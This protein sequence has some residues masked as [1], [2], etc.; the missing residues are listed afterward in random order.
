[1][2]EL[3]SSVRA[4][5]KRDLRNVKTPEELATQ[6]TRRRFLEAI[7]ITTAGIALGGWSVTEMFK[8]LFG[9]RNGATPIPPA[10]LTGEIKAKGEPEVF[11]TRL[12]VEQHLNAL[13]NEWGPGPNKKHHPSLDNYYGDVHYPEEIDE[14]FVEIQKTQIPEEKIAKILLYLNM[15]DGGNVSNIWKNGLDNGNSQIPTSYDAQAANLYKC[16]TYAALFSAL[17]TYGIQGKDWNISYYKNNK[18]NEPVGL[19]PKDVYSGTQNNGE[20]NQLNARFI[21]FWLDEH[22]SAHGWQSIT[23]GELTNYSD[24]NHI[25]FASSHSED[26][27]TEGHD[28]VYFYDKSQ[29]K[30]YLTQSTTNKKMQ[31]E[32]NFDYLFS[33]YDVFAHKIVP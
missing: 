3:H 25:L 32:S 18:T 26:P 23:Q 8:K 31:E 1:M 4:G 19:T 29:E 28:R 11:T 22:G 17:A 24:G 16:N 13:S 33:K 27:N 21:Y 10:V 5:D 2:S 30:W 7:G 9:A 15:Q 20:T 14:G 12:S 6:M